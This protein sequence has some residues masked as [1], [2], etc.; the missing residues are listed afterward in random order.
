MVG[1]GVRGIGM[2]GIPVVKEFSETVEFVGL[3]DINAGRVATA[4]KALGVN[5][6]TYTDFGSDDE[7]NKTRQTDCNYSRWYAS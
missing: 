3:C 1:T 6:T 5:C 4:K 2:W 7:G